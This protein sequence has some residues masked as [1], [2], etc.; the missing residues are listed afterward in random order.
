MSAATSTGKPGSNGQPLTVAALAQA[1]RLPADHLR[2][3]GLYDLHQGGVGIPYYSI[4]GEEIAVKRRT[5][6]KAGEGSYWPQGQPLAAYG[7]NRLDLARKHGWVVLVEGETDCL[8]LWHHGLPALGIPGA[9]T[10]RV[11]QREHVEG[12]STI[13]VHREPDQGGDQFVAG[14]TARLRALGYRGRVHELRMPEGVNDPADLHADDPKR[15]LER[16]QR[17]VGAAKPIG[18]RRHEANGAAARVSPKKPA[19]EPW[20]PFPTDCLPGVLARFVREAAVAMGCDEGF[21]ALPALTACAGLIG[22]TRVLKLRETWH[23]PAVVWACIVGESG[24]LKTPAMNLALRPVFDLQRQLTEDHNADLAAH[25]VAREGWNQRRQQ[26]RRQHRDDNPPAAPFDEP[27]PQRPRSRRIMTSDVTIESLAHL[28]D[29]NQKGLLVYREELRGWLGSFTRYSSTTDL[30]QWL[31]M[32]SAGPVLID[33][34]TGEQRHIFVPHAAVSV[35]G[36]I[37]PGT[38]A[39]ALTDEHRDAGLSA[40]LLMCSPPPREK[41]WSEAEVSP[42]TLTAYADLLGNLAALGFAPTLAGQGDARR[43]VVLEMDEY[44]K[45]EFVNYYTE[46]AKRQAAAEGEHASILSKLEEG[47]ARFALIHAIVDRVSHGDNPGDPWQVH[48]VDIC[49]GVKLAKWFARESVRVYSSLHESESATTTRRLVELLRS[50]GGRVTVAQLRHGHQSRYRTPADAEA[51][52]QVLV[53]DGLAV[54][55]DRPST[56]KGGRPTRECVLVD[57]H[58]RRRNAETQKPPDVG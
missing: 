41:Q 5:A 16:F 7:S 51:E 50:W 21:V 33:R 52:L 8:A 20:V 35:I 43:P 6:L 26:Y 49:A 18:D 29:T 23:A 56:T 58:G 44:A 9:G 28:L 14:V 45:Q 40:R 42:Q 37:Q 38:L 36:S 15:F 17:A 46:W 22:H 54:W 10:A 11:L 30:P 19:P 47:A 39:R 2:A 24:S 1:K 27:E 53:D 57:E 3:V 48:A 31:S 55:E 13:Y 4:E 34:K 25:E 32:H 12:I